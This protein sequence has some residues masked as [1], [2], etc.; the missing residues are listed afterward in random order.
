MWLSIRSNTIPLLIPIK[1]PVVKIKGEKYY[2]RIVEIFMWGIL[3]NT[4]AEIFDIVLWQYLLLLITLFFIVYRLVLRI[5]I[6]RR[7]RFTILLILF[8][9][10]YFSGH[11]NHAVLKDFDEHF[12]FIEDIIHGIK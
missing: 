12:K 6:K 3:L 5:P 4:I 1:I 11:L 9:F 2:I 10:L 8:I 7:Y